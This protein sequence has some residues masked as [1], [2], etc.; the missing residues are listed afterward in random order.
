MI[1]PDTASDHPAAEAVVSCSIGR[2]WTRSHVHEKSIVWH[3][4]SGRWQHIRRVRGTYG[5]DFALQPDATA[6]RNP[7]LLGPLAMLAPLGQRLGD[8]V[9]AAGGVDERLRDAVA[10]EQ[11]FRGEAI[12]EFDH[13]LAAQAAERSPPIQATNREI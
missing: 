1:S 13:E 4:G 8:N 2:H 9:K 7:K 10:R 12:P 11:E 5:M 6:L 3:A